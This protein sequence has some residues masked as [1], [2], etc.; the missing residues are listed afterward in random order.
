MALSCIVSEIFIVYKY[1]DL[2]IRVRAHS[3]SLKV[4]EFHR[5]DMVSY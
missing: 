5:V 3:R 4:V 2:K 1:H